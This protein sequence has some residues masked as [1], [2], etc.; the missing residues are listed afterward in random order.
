MFIF[1]QK[2]FSGYGISHLGNEGTCNPPSP[3]L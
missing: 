2:L 3:G 1:D